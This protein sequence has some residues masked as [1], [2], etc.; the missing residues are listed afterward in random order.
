MVHH[1]SASPTLPTV[2]EIVDTT[3]AT[4]LMKAKDSHFKYLYFDIWAR[5][6]LPRTIL[7]YVGA[8]WEE[9][10]FDWPNQKPLLAPFHQVPILYEENASLRTTIRLNE[11]KAIERYLAE[12]YGLL[13]GGSD[14]PLERQRLD[15]IYNNTDG[16]SIIFDY[17]VL[18]MQGDARV[19][20]ARQFYA[21]AFKQWA[22]HHEALLLKAGGG[23]HHYARSGKTTLADL[24]TALMVRRVL[25]LVP[26][27]ID[28]KADIPVSKEKT[29]ALWRLV[30]AIEQH[31]PMAQWMATERFQ[32]LDKNSKAMM[33]F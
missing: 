29:P 8:S 20:G 24:K 1:A 19:E 4:S 10:K 18:S 13:D 14:D 6:E 26:K 9:I 23:N 25:F 17:T 11:T 28:V 22:E 2:S 30:E 16:I 3:T 31:P 21:G 7:A 12:K 33:G 15:E 32:Q 5:G 27:G